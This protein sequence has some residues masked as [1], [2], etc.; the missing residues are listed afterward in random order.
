MDAVSHTGGV[1]ALIDT[2]TRHAHEQK[3]SEGE[4][5]VLFTKDTKIYEKERDGESEMV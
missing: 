4:R 2:S 1:F 3:Q 5:P